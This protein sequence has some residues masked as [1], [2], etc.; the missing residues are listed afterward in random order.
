MEDVEAQMNTIGV[1][2]SLYTLQ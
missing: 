1:I 2:I